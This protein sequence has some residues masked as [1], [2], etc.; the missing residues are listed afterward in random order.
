MQLKSNAGAGEGYTRAARVIAGW[1]RDM[2]FSDATGNPKVLP[3][4]HGNPDG[5][6]S[7][8]ELARRFSGDIPFREVL[9]ALTKVG[10][11]EQLEDGSIRLKR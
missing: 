3:L 1:V 2:D 5:G 8:A 6:P 10:V 9:D 7:F 4:Q 11:V